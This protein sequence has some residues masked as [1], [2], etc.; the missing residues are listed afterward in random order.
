MILVETGTELL[1]N[2]KINQR[3]DEEEIKILLFFVWHNNCPGIRR[4]RTKHMI[5]RAFTNVYKYF[6][7]SQ[8]VKPAP[9]L[10]RR[11]HCQILNELQNE[12]QLQISR[13]CKFWG[14]CESCACTCKFCGLSNFKSSYDCGSCIRK[15][16]RSCDCAQNLTAVKIWLRAL[17]LYTNH[18]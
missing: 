6:S 17:L 15:N 13:S 5:A 7:P 10:D 14:S 1:L 4:R 8:R 9:A 3:W 12:L 11:R 2:C 18:K 16:Q